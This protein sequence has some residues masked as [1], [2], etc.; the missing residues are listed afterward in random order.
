MQDHHSHARL[1]AHS[2]IAKIGL[3]APEEL[4]FRLAPLVQKGALA[5]INGDVESSKN[6]IREGFGYIHQ[7]DGSEASPFRAN[8]DDFDEL[9]QLTNFLGLS[10]AQVGALGVA[11]N[12]YASN[13]IPG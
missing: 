5:E 13:I 1:K 9:S 8:G 7:L 6:I 4:R 3:F 10:P 12:G 11:T 2:L